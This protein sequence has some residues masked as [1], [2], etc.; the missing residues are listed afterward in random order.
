MYIK[1]R[2]DGAHDGQQL[3][4]IVLEY[5]ILGHCISIA[6]FAVSLDNYAKQPMTPQV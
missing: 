4:S 5:H 2:V 1:P 6:M 3:K